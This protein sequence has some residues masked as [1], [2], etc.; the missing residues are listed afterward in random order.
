MSFFWSLLVHEDLSCDCHS[1]LKKVRL[2]DFSYSCSW[3]S[4]VSVLSL[5]GV[6][7]L[8]LFV[9]S[10]WLFC[11]YVLVFFN[12]FDFADL[13]IVN[14]FNMPTESSFFHLFWQLLFL[15]LLE[16]SRYLLLLFLLHGLLLE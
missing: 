15:L 6:P 7:G 9:D 16:L 14:C 5:P 8:V 4:E 13:N 1:D 3:I 11:R 12:S 2:I 10:T